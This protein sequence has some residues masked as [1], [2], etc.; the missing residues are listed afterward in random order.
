[1]VL[2]DYHNPA[3]L[4]PP[5]CLIAGCTYNHVELSAAFRFPLLAKTGMPQLIFKKIAT[6]SG[7]L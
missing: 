5:R 1:M 7:W 3:S 4:F 6:V 2:D